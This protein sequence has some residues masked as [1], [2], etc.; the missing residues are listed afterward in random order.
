MTAAGPGLGA[1]E[2]Q[3]LFPG[4]GL[5]LGPG[6]GPAGGSNLD[7]GLTMSVKEG[8]DLMMMTAAAATTAATAS[9]SS[10]PGSGHRL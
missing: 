3:G 7:R 4:Q 2:G 8:L 5:F 9:A 10:R 1:V 6:L